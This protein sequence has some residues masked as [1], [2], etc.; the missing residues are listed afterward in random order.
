MNAEL[1]KKKYVGKYIRIHDAGDF[2]SKDYA[3]AWIDIAKSNPMV[4][5]YAY[6]KEVDL[7]KT[8]LSEMI[9]SNFV[10]IYSYGGR[11]DHL[12][13]KDNDRHSDVFP[14]YDEMIAMGYNDI[15]PDDKLAAI[16]PNK[17]VGLY[18][19]N[20]KHFIKKMGNNKFS[21]YQKRPI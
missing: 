19:N 12:I 17:K 4:N 3:M 2:F 1:S 20:I 13:D 16:H 21:D 7:F 6:T 10:L 9:S 18:R 8:E 5:F 15:E 11:Q 14:N